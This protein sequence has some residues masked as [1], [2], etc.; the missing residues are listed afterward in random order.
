VGRGRNRER[1]A[2]AQRIRVE[3]GFG[4]DG[5]GAIGDREE[6]KG[7]GERLREMRKMRKMERGKA[8]G[9]EARVYSGSGGEAALNRIA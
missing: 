6:R 7:R 1:T 2:G 4:R 3:R 8:N 5:E 9:R